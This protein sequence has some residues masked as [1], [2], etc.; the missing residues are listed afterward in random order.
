LT[1]RKLGR[2]YNAQ[3]DRPWRQRRA[4]LPTALALDDDRIRVFVAFLD[5]DMHGRLGFV[6]VDASDPTAVLAVSDEPALDLGRPG[7]F[8][9]SGVNPLS[10]F[11]HEGR[12]W[13]Y[14]VG[15]QGTQALPYLLFTGLAYSD[16]GGATFERHSRVPVLERSEAEPTLRSGAFVRPGRDG[17][18]RAWYVTG[19]TW[20]ESRGRK[21]PA[22]A[23]R[24]L[25][26]E[27]GVSWPE[28][29][30]PCL[31]PVEPD[32]YG[33]GRPYVLDA[34]G[35]LRMWY[36]IRTHSKGYRLGYAESD[37]GIEW[38][39]LDDQVGIDVSASGWDSEMI[40]CGWIQ[41]TRHGTYLFYNGNGYGETGFG[42]AV[43]V[44]SSS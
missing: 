41:Q 23:M 27:D 26:S 8:D 1:W 13:L 24:Y 16:D 25:E 29:G 33:F 9:D 31:T 5:A 28:A 39:R 30:T 38:E 21:R 15:W 10:V 14:Y 18:F 43:L 37:D 4:Y 32:E 22:Y 11:R 44:N 19:D 17:G 40:H 3:G 35:R 6:D 2:V 42:A 7:A 20:I 12:V 36:S 34:G